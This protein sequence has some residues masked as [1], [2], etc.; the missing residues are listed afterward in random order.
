MEKYAD[1]KPM[2]INIETWFPILSLEFEFARKTI[3]TLKSTDI[4][5]V[6][7]ITTSAGKYGKYLFG[8]N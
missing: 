8:Q 1:S 2:H 3:L 5:S 4:P 6:L 7:P